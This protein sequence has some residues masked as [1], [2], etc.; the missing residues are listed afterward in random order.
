MKS[1]VAN[2]NESRRIMH[3]MVGMAPG[4]KIL[5]AAP[6]HACQPDPVPAR[7]NPIPILP[8]NS[9]VHSHIIPIH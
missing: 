7:G 8:G 9:H 2:E 4:L 3:L 6:L 1:K 5:C